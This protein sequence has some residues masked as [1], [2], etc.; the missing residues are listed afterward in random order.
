MNKKWLE[1][2]PPD[3][4]K[5]VRDDATAVTTGILPFVKDF[6]AAQ[7]RLWMDQGGELISLPADEQAA[8]LAKISS[9]GVRSVEGQA[10][11]RR[12]GEVRDGL[13]GAQQGLRSGTEPIGLS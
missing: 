6:Y 5:I 9:I 10:G 7:R 2:L 12:G 8:Y 3:L 1:D 4:Q 13:G 11:A